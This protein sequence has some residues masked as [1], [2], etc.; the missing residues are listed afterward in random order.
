[1]K[2]TIKFLLFFVMVFCFTNALE[3][4]EGHC[5]HCYTDQ[6]FNNQRVDQ[7]ITNEQGVFFLVDGLWFGAQGM[8]AA[9]EGIFLLEDGEW[10]PLHEVV[11]CGG[12]CLWWKCPNPVCGKY[13][14]QS[15]RYC[16]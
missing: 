2:A 5:N 6:A 13:N 8:Q 14:P 4:F 15:V 11:R 10:M 7:L 16:V 1:M 3:A 12:K 9:S